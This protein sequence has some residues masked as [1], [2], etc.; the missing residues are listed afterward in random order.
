M[1]GINKPHSRFKHVYAV[2]RI[3]LPPDEST[4]ENSVTVIKVF[5]SET[6]AKREVSRLNKLNQEKGCKYVMNIT[7]MVP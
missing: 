5:S 7:R 2:V 3:D 4:P 6:A 1:A